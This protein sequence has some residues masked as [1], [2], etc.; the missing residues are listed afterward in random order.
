M[1]SNISSSSGPARQPSKKSASNQTSSATQFSTNAR[2]RNAS[3]DDDPLAFPRR[4]TTTPGNPFS[5]S[6]HNNG[7]NVNPLQIQRPR[8]TNSFAENSVHAPVTL[9]ED[10][11]PGPG[12]SQFRVPRMPNGAMGNTMGNAAMG[13]TFMGNVD[14]GMSALQV[15]I[16]A[17]QRMTN[18]NM[19]EGVNGMDWMHGNGIIPQHVARQLVQ[20][21]TMNGTMGALTGQLGNGLFTNGQAGL[22]IMNNT[23]GPVGNGNLVPVANMGIPMMGNGNTS[24]ASTGSGHSFGGLDLSPA[25]LAA[26]HD[27]T[28]D[29]SED[30]ANGLPEDFQL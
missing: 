22:G 27:F 15:P 24:N 1:S 26:A 2:N 11:T 14:D 21:A 23:H 10:F 5:Y 30:F 16:T 13:N 3:N 25:A 12:V 17:G 7:G 8:Q 28:L 18:A 4:T 19:G 6:R 20:M 9:S 29:A